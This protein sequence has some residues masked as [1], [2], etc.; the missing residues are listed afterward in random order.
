[1]PASPTVRI[2]ESVIAKTGDDRD[3]KIG[4]GTYIRWNA[5][6]VDGSARDGDSDGFTVHGYRAWVNVNN[7]GEYEQKF[8]MDAYGGDESSLPRGVYIRVRGGKSEKIIF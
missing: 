4:Y 2:V 3:G 1:M 5:E 7:A 8:G 6:G